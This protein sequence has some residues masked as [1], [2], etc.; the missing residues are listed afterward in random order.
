MQLEELGWTPFFAAYLAEIEDDKL[1]A[2]RV[3]R[4]DGQRY[5]LLTA[6][7][8]CN[9]EMAGRM[10]HL[11]QQRGDVPVV[12]D[13][14]AVQYRGADELATIQALL[15][16]RSSFSRRAVD[17]GGRGGRGGKAEEQ[18]VAANIDTVFLVSALDGT[19]NFNL[20]RLE[21][22]LT[23]AW[24]SGA[25]PV[26]V[27]NKAD[28]CAEPE[29]ALAQVE[30]LAGGVPV[31]LVSA[32]E[33]E[34]LQPLT[35]YL[36]VG[37]T[38]ACLGP[39][40]VGKSTLINGLQGEHQVA[41][42]AVRGGDLRGRHTTTWSELVALP[43]GGLII[44]TPGMRDVQL[45]ASEDSL[46]DTFADIE[47]LALQCRFRNCGHGGEVGCAIGA[48]LAEGIL[49]QVRYDS[50]LKLKRELE[51]VASREDKNMQLSAKERDKEFARRHKKMKKAI[52]RGEQGRF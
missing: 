34:G 40:G 18:V 16:R 19:R 42:G 3:G 9:G 48:A 6:E 45:W 24:D 4:Q 26:I 7:G 27:L 35:D 11:L 21:R 1:I 10:R 37:Q 2:A 36:A 43:G 47:E 20:Q 33:E 32:V 30:A 23:L 50:Y 51:Y 39:S 12:G 15:P 41:T 17:A 52:K 46:Q 49:E 5:R 29:V 8:S 28:L 38:C 25:N 13:W 22:Y 14:V 31:H 44:D